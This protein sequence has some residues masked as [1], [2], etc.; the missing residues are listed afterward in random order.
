MNRLAIFTVIT[1]LTSMKTPDLHTG[2]LIRIL[3][4]AGSMLLLP[5]AGLTQEPAPGVR[6][7][8][9]ISSE[10]P[11]YWEYNGRPVMLLGGSV[12][13][14]LFQIPGLEA[15]LDLLASVGGNYIRNTMSSRDP[16]NVWAFGK[17]PESGKYD[18]NR[19]NETYWERFSSL[20]E[21]TSRREIIVQVEVWA[22]FDFYRENW[23]VNPFNPANNVN[24]SAGRT[25]L[26]EV[27]NTHPTYCDNPFF[28]SIPSHRNNMRVLE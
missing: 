18:L 1:Y 21:L 27:V 8:I 23:S 12:E 6:A 15:H 5:A 25:D 17:D 24:Y 28:W 2:D 16:G 3:A 10:Y 20:L 11:Q 14:N 22:T 7:G 4:A 9:D 19:W 13:D 26:P